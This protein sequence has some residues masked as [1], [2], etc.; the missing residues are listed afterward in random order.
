MNGP[1]LNMIVLMLELL[2]IF[3]EAIAVSKCGSIKLDLLKSFSK[4]KEAPV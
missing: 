1:Q 3:S 2:K 4:I